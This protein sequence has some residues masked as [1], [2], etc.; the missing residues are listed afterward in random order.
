M[1][2]EKDNIEG[3]DTNTETTETKKLKLFEIK[4]NMPD[5]L[6]QKLEKFNRQTSI[7]NQ[8]IDDMN[9]AN[10]KKREEEME[11]DDDLFGDYSND[12]SEEDSNEDES[13]EENNEVNFDEMKDLF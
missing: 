7:L 11:D 2:L 10:S 12:S 3:L 6:K 5:E 1:D 9:M 13:I 8:V 4:E